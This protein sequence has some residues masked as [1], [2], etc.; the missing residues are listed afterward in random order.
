MG[1]QDQVEDNGIMD[2][3]KERLVGRGFSQVEG[4]DFEE[5][6]SLII[7]ATTIKVVL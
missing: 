2:R 6:F 4:L 1:V 5:T 3:Y 7:K